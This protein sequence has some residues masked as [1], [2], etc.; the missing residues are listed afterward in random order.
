ML[1][2]AGAAPKGHGT[3]VASLSGKKPINP[4]NGG[5]FTMETPLDAVNAFFNGI[6]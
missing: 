4:G 6:L 1:D 5:A 3:N 2:P